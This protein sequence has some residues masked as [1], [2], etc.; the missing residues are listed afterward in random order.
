MFA[1]KNIVLS[2]W[3]AWTLRLLA[4]PFRFGPKADK[5]K[6]SED[7]EVKSTENSGEFPCG[8]WG[9]P[10]ILTTPFFWLWLQGCCGFIGM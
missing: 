3:T 8:F 6:D 4:L 2:P 9:V 5:A 7:L 1:T 10:Y